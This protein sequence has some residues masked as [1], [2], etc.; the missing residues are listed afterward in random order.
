[1]QIFHRQSSPEF[2]RA[3][4]T[5]TR[6]TVLQTLPFY[7]AHDPGSSAPNKLKA[8]LVCIEVPGCLV[9]KEWAQMILVKNFDDQRGL[10]VRRALGFFGLWVASRS[11]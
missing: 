11:A 5:R 1:M 9:L 10:A 7:D 6:L 2:E 8:V 3:N 4:P